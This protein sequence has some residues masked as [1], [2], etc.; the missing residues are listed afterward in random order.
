MTD[1]VVAPKADGST[2]PAI[3]E[4][5]KIHIEPIIQNPNVLGLAMI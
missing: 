3:K 1:V 5:K 2:L 4:P